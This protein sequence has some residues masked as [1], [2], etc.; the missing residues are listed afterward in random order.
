MVPVRLN[1]WREPSKVVGAHGGTAASRPAL[2]SSLNVAV[3]SNNTKTARVF[4]AL[5]AE[6]MQP[7]LSINQSSA[8]N[9]PCGHLLLAVRRSFLAWQVASGGRDVIHPSSGIRRP[10]RINREKRIASISECNHQCKNNLA[11]TYHHADN[12]NY[13]SSWLRIV[14]IYTVSFPCIH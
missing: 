12:K 14:Y 13:T 4:G 8:G 11:K 3:T 1:L 6:R 7:K 5:S 10:S 2:F 9:A